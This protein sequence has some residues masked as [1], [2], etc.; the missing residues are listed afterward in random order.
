MRFV[1]PYRKGFNILSSS[2]IGG[3]PGRTF[4][5]LASFSLPHCRELLGVSQGSVEAFHEKVRAA[6]KLGPHPHRLQEGQWVPPHI[7]YR[8]YKLSARSTLTRSKL[9]VRRI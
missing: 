5:T 4:R 7:R 6:N 8:L 3:R 9:W 2:R 1:R